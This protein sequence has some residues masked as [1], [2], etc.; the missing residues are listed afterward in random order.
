MDGISH[1]F[2]IFEGDLAKGLSKVDFDTQ[3]KELDNLKNE[4]ETT[5]LRL[6]LLYQNLRTLHATYSY[7]DNLTPDETMPNS[8]EKSLLHENQSITQE[9]LDLVA[10]TVDEEIV[11]PYEY[12]SFIQKD[13]NNNKEKRKVVETKTTEVCLTRSRKRNHGGQVLNPRK[14]YVCVTC[15]D[16]H[17]DYTEKAMRSHYKTSHNRIVKEGQLPVTKSQLEEEVEYD[18]QEKSLICWFCQYKADCHENLWKH[19]SLH[20]PRQFCKY[21]CSNC[22]EAYVLRENL[23]CHEMI[24]LNTK[25]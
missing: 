7:L 15:G 24:C 20:V 8:T 2:T 21:K 23:E 3:K 10:N 13:L 4:N 14:F 11:D 12:D 16:K 17:M 9:V 18:K 22:P 19:K 25:D 1:L 6:V 5:E